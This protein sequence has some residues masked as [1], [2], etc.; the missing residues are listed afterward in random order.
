MSRLLNAFFVLFSMVCFVFF[1]VCSE[2]RTETEQH[3][4]EAALQLAVRKDYLWAWLRS[5]VFVFVLVFFRVY[6]AYSCV[7]LCAFVCIS[8]YSCVFV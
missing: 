3:T 2:N 7:Y 1:T 4:D 5:H 6:R 8:V